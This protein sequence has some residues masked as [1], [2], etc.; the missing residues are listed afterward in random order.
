MLCCVAGNQTQSGAEGEFLD[1]MNHR[2]S[3]EVKK[4]ASFIVYGLFV[5]FTY[6][7]FF[8]WLLVEVDICSSV[9][10]QRA[11]ARSLLFRELVYTYHIADGNESHNDLIQIIIIQFE[12]GVV[13]GRRILFHSFFIYLFEHFAC[14]IALFRK[15]S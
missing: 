2:H 7:R 4:S 9:N 10:T 11:R 12:F 5:Y 8:I 1:Q 3:Y 6:F 14:S 13:V 15:A